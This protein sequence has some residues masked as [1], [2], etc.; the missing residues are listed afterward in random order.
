[1]PGCGAFKTA[2]L[3]SVAL[4]APY[5]HTGGF[6]SLWDVVAFYNAGAGTDGYIGHRDP[7][8]GPLYLSDD[9]ITDIVSF[10]ES[11]TGAPIPDEWAHCPT[12]IPATACMA[13]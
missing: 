10:L 6:D 2:R 3:R 1:M 5:M 4:T 13:P 7:A 11:L 8:I 9:E 12:T